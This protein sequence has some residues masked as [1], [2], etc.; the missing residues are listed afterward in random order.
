[1][2]IGTLALATIAAWIPAAAPAASAAEGTDALKGFVIER[3]K[4]GARPKV[5]FAFGS[6]PAAPAVLLAADDDGVRVKTTGPEGF[7]MNVAW[8]KVTE[9][10]LYQ[11]GRPLVADMTAPACAA[12]LQLGQKL[13]HTQDDA[14]REALGL[15]RKLQ[16]GAAAAAGPDAPAAK[17]NGE[18]PGGAAKPD[19]A[20]APPAP[21]APRTLRRAAAPPAAAELAPPESGTFREQARPADAFVDTIGVNIHLGYT[22]TVYWKYEELVKPRLLE[23]GVRHV[24]DGLR[25]NRKDV[26]QRLDD[27]AA[28][29]IRSDLILHPADG[30]EVAKACAAS[31][32]TVEGPNEPDNKKKDWIPSARDD[33]TALYQAIKSDPATA[34]LPVLVSAMANTRDSPGKLGALAGALDFGNMHSY[35]GGLNP[36]S[37]GWGISLDRAIAEERKVCAEKPIFVTETGYHNRT[38]QE[39]HPGV[40]EAVAA[41]YLPRLHLHYFNT[42]IVRTFSYELLDLFPDPGMT[43][44]ERH[45]GL[46]RNDGSPKPAFTALR[47]LIRILKDP[48]PPFAADALGYALGGETHGVRR[49]VLQKRDKTFLVIFWLEVVGYDIAKRQEIPVS[50]QEVIFSP[51]GAFS[52]AVLYRPV[53]TPDPISEQKAPKLMMLHVSD[54]PL[55]VRLVPGAGD[56]E[57]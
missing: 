8:A 27:L 48:G 42:G 50:P 21:E 29:G 49:T 22:D 57:R 17:A 1:M 16:A 54:E 36:T 3:V 39:G 45:F 34:R 38:A 11:F 14:Y 19:E 20:K 37:G 43:D 12:F 9:E 44:M 2:R 47:N 15:A 31:V 24:R 46:A 13:N 23:L 4:G 35:P 53:L 52:K 30:V 18:R 28:N 56:G 55:I 51:G 41:R 33:Q 7:E 6:M 26:V 40:P 32:L 25:A 10:N 5:Q